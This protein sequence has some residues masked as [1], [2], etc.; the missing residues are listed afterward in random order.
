MHGGSTVSRLRERLADIVD[1]LA[2]LITQIPVRRF[3]RDSYG[4]VFAVPDYCW[5]D[6]SNEQRAAQVTLKR[7]YD[8]VSELFRLLLVGAP[9]DLVRQLEDADA[10]FRVWLQLESNW[11]LASRP[12]ANEAAMRSDVAALDQVLAVLEATGSTE[13]IVV[14]DTNSLLANPKPM[15]YRVIAGADTMVFALLP[16]VLGELDRLKI[17][18]RNPDVCDKAKKVINRV[19]GWRQQGS[20]ASGVTVDKSI[21]VRALHV[22][23]NMR[24]SLS[25]LDAAVQDD[26]IVASVIALQAEHPAARVVLVTGD[27]NLQNKAD[28]AL[29]ETADPP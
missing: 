12:D 16:T 5:D 19:K 28:A 7:Q 27:I 18:H 2:R 17:E 8:P 3:R 24:A 11:G 21:T 9:E 26:R 4:I 13:V 25:W 20:L 6:L 23:P 14:P 15:D 1:G 29:I 10:R 22:E